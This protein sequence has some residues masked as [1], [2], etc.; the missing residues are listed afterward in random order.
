MFGMRA[1]TLSEVFWES[2]ESF[3]DQCGSLITEF[4]TDLV[5]ERAEE[6]AAAIR[7]EGAPIENCIGF[8]DCT[9]IQMSRTG[10]P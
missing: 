5:Q 6:Y 3:V 2:I 8:M 7:S 4:R 10:G 1:H 9:K